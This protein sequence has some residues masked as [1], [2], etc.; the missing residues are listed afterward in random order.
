MKIK[1]LLKIYYNLV[2]YTVLKTQMMPG[3]IKQYGENSMEHELLKLD[4]DE[5]AECVTIVYDL[6][7]EHCPD[8]RELK[9]HISKNLH[10]DPYYKLMNMTLYDFEK[11]NISEIN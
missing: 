6:L 9:E 8:E 7:K 3:I 4:L 11:Y 2:T 5:M 1:N 10:L